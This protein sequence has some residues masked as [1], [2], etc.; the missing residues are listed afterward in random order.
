[1]K[2][3][4]EML[5]TSKII[6]FVPDSLKEFKMP[7]SYLNENLDSNNLKLF[8]DLIL[9]TLILPTTSYNLD[10]LKS[11]KIFFERL[12][13]HRTD[14]DSISQDSLYKY[15]DKVTE[16]WQHHVGRQIGNKYY[17]GTIDLSRVKFNRDSTLCALE[18]GYLAQSKCGYGNYILLKKIN[19]KW[20]ILK[21][22]GSWVS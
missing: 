14:L 15:Y 10:S 3:H 22:I 16:Y 21:T 8:Q 18:C 9:D 4:N 2:H 19:G 11:K 13:F 20:T 5:D 17:I 7:Y 1:M 12:P 6:A